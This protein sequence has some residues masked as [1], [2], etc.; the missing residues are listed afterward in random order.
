MTV[1]S[2]ILDIY[3]PDLLIINPNIESMTISPCPMID[4]SIPTDICTWI[5]S[6]G[7]W[8][9]ITAYDIMTLVNAYLNLVPIGFTV[10]MAHILGA[11]SYYSGI[12]ESGNIYT[13]CSFT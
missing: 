3:G 9:K 10:T 4:V 1:S 11:I 7:G 5:I 8:T 12:L 6:Q 2:I 13:G